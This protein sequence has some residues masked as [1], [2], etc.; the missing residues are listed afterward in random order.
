MHRWVTEVVSPPLDSGGEASLPS[1]AVGPDHTVSI[2]YYAQASGSG[3]PSVAIVQSSDQGQHF[4]VPV[5][6]APLHMAIAPG[7]FGG[8]LGL[9]GT[10]PDGAAS[11][12]DA[13]SSPQVVA[14]PVSGALYI[15]YVDATQDDRSNIYFTQSTDQGESW[16]SPVR[17]ND[18]ATTSD[19]FLPAMGVS[20]DGTRLAIDFY[21]RRDDAANQNANRY[22]VTADISGSTVTF[23]PNF[24][25][26]ALPF[27]VL[28]GVDPYLSPTYFSIRTSMAA[29]AN[30]FYDAYAD[31]LDGHLDVRL[32]RYGVRF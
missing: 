6:V 9:A 11:T 14:N 19:Q 5:A 27:P 22:G 7:S 23:G 25:I 18:D 3:G 1:V 16:S 20:L 28:V 17:V 2:A 4:D 12:F 26:S 29:D 13:Y 15:A 21:D 31:S 30:Y 10:G 8:N 24:R 32:G